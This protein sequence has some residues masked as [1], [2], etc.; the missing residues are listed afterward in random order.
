[1]RIK[2]LLVHIVITLILLISSST[3]GVDSSPIVSNDLKS[4]YF[5]LSEDRIQVIEDHITIS[6]YKADQV[7]DGHT[8]INL[9]R[10]NATTGGVQELYVVVIELNGSISSVPSGFRDQN[11]LKVANA[12]TLFGTGVNSEGNKTASFWNMETN[13]TEHAVVLP[14]S[15][16]HDIEY[17]PITDTFLVLSRNDYGTFQDLPIT[18][19]EIYEINRKGEIMFNWNGS[20]AIPFDENISSEISRGKYDFQHG[21]A[22]FWD[23]ELDLIY[24][25]ARH[26]DTVYAIDHKTGEIAWSVGRIGNLKSIAKN[27]TEIDSL[28]YHTHAIEKIAPNRFIIFD[29]DKFNLTRENPRIGESRIVEFEVDLSAGVAREIWTWTPDGENYYSS[30][31]GDAD[32][33]PNGNRMALFGNGVSGFDPGITHPM[34]VTEVNNDGE[35]VWEILFNNSSDFEWGGYRADRF[36]DAPIVDLSTDNFNLESGEKVTISASVWNSFRNSILYDASLIIKEG[37]TTLANKDFQFLP[38]WQETKIDE[39][40]DGLLPGNHMLEVIIQNKDG[41]F[42]SKMVS[43]TVNDDISSSSIT[44]TSSSS[45]SSD[46]PV[47]ILP[48]VTGMLVLIPLFK[49]DKL[50]FQ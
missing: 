23:H 20:I 47:V 43:V 30:A 5:N 36:Y 48:V 24:Y 19:D 49:K 16:H 3:L 37:D 31:W 27:G 7:I 35:I 42:T 1:M 44:Q 22:I 6:E 26:L 15:Q 39:D 41:R 17:N 33:L 28:F 40:I 29:N 8:M 11:Y 46:S 14:G 45:N 32:R 10:Y 12:T 9:R 25:S 38:Y 50:I 13:V 34:R 4:S 21:N 18:F 2:S